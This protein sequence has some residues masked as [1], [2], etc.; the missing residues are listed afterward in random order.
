MP[1]LIPEVIPNGVKSR[2][3]NNGTDKSDNSDYSVC[4]QFTNIKSILK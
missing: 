2:S 3:K 4:E 1:E